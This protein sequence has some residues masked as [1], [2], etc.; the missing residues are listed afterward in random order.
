MH[1]LLNAGGGS[2]ALSL[3]EVFQ[4]NDAVV[5]E[6]THESMR[7]DALTAQET[8]AVLARGFRFALIFAR[9]ANGFLVPLGGVDAHHG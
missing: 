3:V 8:G 9:G 7:R 1:E 6:A 4:R 5:F 2:I